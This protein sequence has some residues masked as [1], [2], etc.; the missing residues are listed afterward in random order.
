MTPQTSTN[1]SLFYP[2]VNYA[3]NQDF[4]ING[5]YYQ[6][7]GINIKGHNGLD[8]HGLHGQPIYAAHD[9]IAYYETD[10]Q[11][12][13]GVVLITNDPFPYKADKA[14]FKTI[15]WHMCDPIKEPKFASPIFTAIGGPNINKHID[16]RR[17]DLLGYCDST[18]FSGGD[19]L[20]FGLK[21]ILPNTQFMVE[22]ATDVG[23]GNW[24]N[25]EQANGYL[26]AINP[27]PYWTGRYAFER[28]E[29]L[30]PA[31]AVAVIAA[32][33]QAAG[34]SRMASIL[35]AIVSVI[36][37]FLVGGDNSGKPPAGGTQ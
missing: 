32:Q 10:D 20:H 31:D 12:G 21:P 27:T 24:R 4:G 29:E 36:K 13:H 16:I 7:H 11:Q 6:Q 8:L 26:G 19:H 34:D 28:T 35:W 1:F 17:G 14:Y 25:V 23:I 9:G 22:D 3:V 37:A 30:G 5:L 15:Y 2:M 33:K 18:G